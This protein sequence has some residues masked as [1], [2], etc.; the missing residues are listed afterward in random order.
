MKILHLLSQTELTGAEVYAQNLVQ[1]QVRNQHQVHVISD[2]IHVSLPVPWQ[3]LPISTRSTWQRLQNI[4][5]LRNFLIR[6]KIEVIHCHSRGAVRHAYWARMGLPVALVTTLH[7]RQH[8]S[9]SKRLWNIYGEIQIGICE[10]VKKAMELDF[11]HPVS[12]IRILRNPVSPPKMKSTSDLSSPSPQLALIGR[13]SGPKGE[14][15]EKIALNCFERWLQ[16]FP[17]L[18]ISIVAPKPERFSQDLHGLIARLNQNHPDQVK[19]LGHVPELQDQLHRFDLVL[20]SGRIAIESLLAGTNV[21]AIGENSA[22]GLVRMDRLSDCLA[23]N[24][25]DIGSGEVETHLNLETVFKEIQ[26][27]F[28][29]PASISNDFRNLQ[30]QIREE[31]DPVHINEGI[32][33]S[34]RAA[35][36]KRQVPAWIPILMYHKVPEQDLKSQH[37]IFVTR[38]NFKKHLQF[39]KG[40][41]FQTLRFQDLQDYWTEK[42]PLAEFP[43]KPLLLT[44]DDGYIDNR[45]HAEP[46]LQEYGFQATIFLLANHNITENTW[47]ANTGEAPDRLMSLEEKKLL[48]PKVWEIG[49]H[50]FNHLHLPQISKDQAIQE[51]KDSRLQLQADFKTE[52]LSFAYPFGSTNPEIAKLAEK[53]GYRFAV[54]TDQGGLHLADDPYSLF[55]VNIFPEDGAFELWKKTAPW[56]R[57]YFYRKRKR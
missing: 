10:N 30:N 21:F 42:K 16:V 31:F 20:C 55:R 56:Y 39:F 46:L 44:F 43:R 26:D 32:L 51:M 27:F 52:I 14:R 15:F 6:E 12:A 23:S 13:S 49:S 24:F 57:K 9:W 38:E 1:H 41:G 45:L 34:Y 53:A 36:F 22:P 19:L 33:E 2:R 50:G 8:F 4:L 48:N 28:K 18:H 37:R 29:Q 35:R 54:N 47:D 11:R 5:K 25:G 7:G 40:Q 3:P 17:N